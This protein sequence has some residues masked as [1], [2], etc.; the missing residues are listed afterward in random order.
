MI[1]GGE[2]PF[3][4]E[5]EITGQLGLKRKILSVIGY[6]RIVNPTRVSYFSCALSTMDMQKDRL[7]EEQFLSCFG[8]I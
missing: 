1:N 7:E 2:I 8:L 6:T 4:A 3:S 5:G